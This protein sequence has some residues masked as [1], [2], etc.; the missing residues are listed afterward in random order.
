MD[1]DAMGADRQHAVLKK[2][3]IPHS[4]V[5]L[6]GIAE[7]VRGALCHIRAS[8]FLHLDVKPSNIAFESN[9]GHA[10]LTD[11]NL[12]MRSPGS[13]RDAYTGAGPCTWPY[14]PP[15][16]W[17]VKD[18]TVV[19]MDLVTPAVNAFALGIT[20]VETGSLNYGVV[21][22]D[23]ADAANRARRAGVSAPE[24]WR[25]RVERFTRL[26]SLGEP[27]RVRVAWLLSLSK[28]ARVATLVEPFHSVW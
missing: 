15:E 22:E 13:H 14:R 12:A 2:R 10:Y 7:Q 1:R 23:E 9:I 5:S 18:C 27:E 19:P 26:L 6:I 3:G 20:I 8:G 4:G 28:R 17:K 16:V 25:A 24:R 21:R 11:F